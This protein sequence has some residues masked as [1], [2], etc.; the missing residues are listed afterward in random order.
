MSTNQSKNILVVEDD[1][2]IRELLETALTL[3]GYQVLTA[4]QGEEAWD[5]LRNSP[6]APH[7]LILD[8]MMPVMDGIEL[9][10]LKNE[11][12]NHQ[13][14]PTIV[15]SAASEKKFPMETEYQVN[16]RKPLDLDEFLRRVESLI[17]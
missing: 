5:I 10:R 13:K 3:E 8:L 9:L 1:S 4:T 16:M 12:S 7:L 6:T 17:A 11:S 14:I 2:A 15:M